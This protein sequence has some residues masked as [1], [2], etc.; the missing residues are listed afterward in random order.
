MKKILLISFITIS[1]F[2]NAQI[3]AIPD[4]NFEASLI[5]SGIDTDGIVNG[6]MATIDA[7]NVTSLIINNLNI[8]DLTGIEAFISLQSISAVQNQLTTLDF[9]PIT[10]ITLI[11]VWG[12]NL[13]SINVSTNTALQVL[14]VNDNQLTTL[15][16]SNNLLIDE[17]FCENNSITSLDLSSHSLLADLFIEN[18]ALTCL[19]VKN[20]NNSNFT[21]FNVVGNPSLTCIEVDNVSFSITNWTVGGGMTFSTNCPSSCLVGVAEYNTTELSI[22]PNPTINTL[23]IKSYELNISKIE[24]IDLT[25]KLV[26][27]IT[28]DLNSLNVADLQTGIYFIRIITDQETFTKK[29]AKQ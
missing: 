8:S 3:T 1:S 2:L 21:T 13:T 20:G 17:L 27:T 7:A 19:N 26:K 14:Y 16:I 25:G 10:T 6:Q 23:T 24:I 11:T 4:A 22:Y 12:N 9:S 18:N 15:D 28:S 29:F 5:S